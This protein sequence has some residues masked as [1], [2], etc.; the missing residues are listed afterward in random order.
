MLYPFYK[1]DIEKGVLTREKA[2]EYITDYY[3]KHNLIMGRGEHQVGNETN[4][5]TFKRILNF[6]APQYLLL[7][8]TDERGELA[9]N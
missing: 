1:A 3:C 7:A 4:S 2:K 5:T 8:G 6:D 9:V